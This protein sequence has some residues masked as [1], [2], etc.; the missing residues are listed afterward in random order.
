VKL[1]GI[2]SVDFDVIYQ[3]LIRYSAFVRFWR[4]KWEC[5]GTV[6]QVFVDSKDHVSGEEKYCT[7]F[8]FNLVYL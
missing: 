8:L 7:I 3:I 6:H 1:L 5:N 2:I 4:K